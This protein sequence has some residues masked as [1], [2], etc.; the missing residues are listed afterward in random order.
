MDD[1]L[2]NRRKESVQRARQMGGMLKPL[3]GVWWIASYPKSGNTWIRVVLSAYLSD[4]RADINKLLIPGEIDPSFYQAACTYPLT[5]L[6]N[7]LVVSLRP[8]AILNLMSANAGLT[9]PTILKSHWLY[10]PFI[11]TP[12]V[13]TRGSVYVIRDPR[14]VAVSWAEHQ[15][16][17][18][19]EAIKRMSDKTLAL[20][21]NDT[22]LSAIVGSWSD[23]VKSW[24]GKAHF[25][26]YED[27]LSNPYDEFLKIVNHIGIEIDEEALA[28][29]VESSEFSKL[30]AQEERE[31]FLELWK[32]DKFFGRGK[33]GGW[34]DVLTKQQQARI[35]SDHG[36]MM[37]KF[38]YLGSQEAETPV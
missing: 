1:K 8:A 10:D 30:K 29:S 31:G 4:A 2:A 36:E 35:E 9:S 26:R 5:A 15:A 19:D 20:Q 16:Q 14:D 34:K 11:A 24:D 3:D 12:A 27:L 22:P 18:V 32:G 7:S 38:G 23:N 13:L 28:Q 25:V 37:A 21:A 33:A 17:S 6:S